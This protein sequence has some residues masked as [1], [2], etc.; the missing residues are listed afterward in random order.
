MAEEKVNL[1]SPLNREK[2]KRFD[3]LGA[4]S[5]YENALKLIPKEGSKRI[6]DTLERKA[7]ALYKA[8]LQSETVDEFHDRANRAAKCYAEAK[9]AQLKVDGP[10]SR[11]RTDRCDAMLAF[12]KFLRSADGVERK[13]HSDDSW[14]LAKESMDGFAI[15]DN[16]LEFCKTYNELSFSAVFSEQLV[17]DYQTRK[18]T[19]TE[20]VKYGEKAAELSRRSDDPG[21][22]I[23][24]LVL[25]SGLLEMAGEHGLCG[26]N[27]QSCHKKALDYWQRA[28][29]ISKDAVLECLPYAWIMGD[30]PI[31]PNRDMKQELMAFEK[32]LELVRKSGDR[33]AIGHA[34]AGLSFYTDWITDSTEDK[35]VIDALKKKVLSYAIDS[36]NEFS[37]IGL[38][39]RAGSNI[40]VM[41]PHA[42]YY[43]YLAWKENDLKRKREYAEKSL[44]AVPEFS[45]LAHLSGYTW[46]IIDADGLEGG[47]L[48]E[49]A[50]TEM[51]RDRRRALLERAVDC[52]TR[53][54][55]ALEQYDAAMKYNLG[56]NHGILADILAGLAEATTDRES[57][58]RA[59]NEAIGLLKKAIEEYTEGMTEISMTNDPTSCHA[60]G[61]F[62]GDLG[63]RYLSLYEIVGDSSCMNC[64]IE[65]FEKSSNMYLKAGQP[66][67]AAE[68]MW[69]AAKVYDQLDDSAKAAERFQ[70]A[71]KLFIASGENIPRLKGLYSDYATYLEAWAEFERAKYHHVRQEYPQA[72]AHFKTAAQL[73]EIL[74]K[75]RFLAS[76]YQ[77]WALIDR[78][79]AFS[80][81]DRSA[82]AAQAFEEADNL[83]EK[84]RT[85][86]EEAN[87]RA[88]NADEK[89]M[90]M[91]LLVAS[92]SR[93]KYCQARAAIETARQMDIKGM[94]SSSSE[95]YKKA[96]DDLEALASAMSSEQDKREMKLIAVLSRAW[97]K[98]NQAEAEVSSEPYAEA[99]R[100][101]EE[102]KDLCANDKLKALALGNSRF[103][104]AL[105]A[106]TR[107][108]DTR[109]PSLHATATKN[110]ESASSFYL[111][112]GADNS[113][114]YARAS[115]LLFDAY[116]YLD[117]AS[118]EKDQQKSAKTYALAAKVLHASSESYAKAG[119]PG[120][121]DQVMKF[122]DRVKKDRELA[123]SLTE[124]FEAPVGASSTTAFGAPTP[125]QEEAVGLDRFAH[126]DIQ[127]T[128]IA[129]SED[130]KIGEIFDLVIELVNAGRG[131]AQLIKLQDP[132]PEGFTLREEPGGYRMEDSYLNL[133][134]KR[135]DPLKTEEIKLV[136]KP[137]HRGQFVLKPRILY[138]DESG[139][140]KSHEPEPMRVTVGDEATEPADKAFPT[141]T[142]E[143]AEARSL[144]AGLNVVT[145]SHYR[146]VGNYVRYG[147]AVC[148]SLKDARQKIMAGCRSSSPKRENYIIWAPPGS[149]KT[150]FVQ[151]VAALLGDSVYYRELNL[152]KLDEAGFRSGLV[153]LRDAQ[154]PCLCLVDE[155]DAKP[156][157][158]WPYEV[159]MPFLDA[160]ATEGARLVFVL[161]GSSGSS[162][163]EMKRTLASRTK[164]SDLLSRVPTDNEYSIPPMGVGD[165]LLVV[166]SQFRQAGKQMGRDVREVEKLGLYYVAL[167]P[168][169]SNARQLREF[170]VRCAER[171]LPGDDRLKYDSLFQP[172]D[173]ENK[174]FWRDALKSA[175][176]LVN[177]FLLVED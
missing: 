117:E 164:G 160:S 150:Y 104:K 10:E 84:S 49:L 28:E 50:K 29:A 44:D 152:A 105:Q 106:G 96:A 137:T 173:L 55:K 56:M 15:V 21:V 38:L 102:A 16:A 18:K 85:S 94:N 81:E 163:E 30:A 40:W 108:A 130:V 6:A 100:L 58:I 118:Q 103:C 19:V 51:D 159:L 33:L 9:D 66:S 39:A 20:A 65:S 5:D 72:H 119:Q 116:A 7:Y 12:M 109:E 13:R 62:Q 112:A 37:K 95:M 157:E 162:L 67:R 166:L 63:E 74:P 88:E 11:A 115:K 168:R 129:G 126:A 176:D 153:E 17:P 91:G 131:P 133:R 4:A 8:A 127:A 120:K 167:N 132:V 24:T 42:A 98:M 46:Y 70:S 60:L 93:R 69:E 59:M 169:L 122:L 14:R 155:V 25:I 92:E 148:N 45:R 149:G 78:A 177:S 144:L 54:V 134:G 73:H 34:L 114:E 101:F 87:K 71:S 23:R 1:E 86:L 75:W 113:A 140:Y 41:S 48:N 161:A 151:E 77:A 36:K 89:R 99:A 175:G 125:T 165:R 83:F 171:V 22:T 156:D 57:K 53:A 123:L 136:L 27:A 139:K 174:L 143:A 107:F 52:F 64:A 135:L 172:G 43:W 110:L 80:R 76:N 90:I 158:S 145:L 2:E 82:E 97:Q 111:I 61:Q 31:D 154:G 138:L 124:V 147:G 68:N 141:D 32:A 79:E 170:A 128:L 142:R 47:S 35:E 146:I 26:E 3:W 121:R